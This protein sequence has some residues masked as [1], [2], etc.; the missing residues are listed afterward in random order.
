MVFLSSKTQAPIFSLGPCE[1][2]E[3]EDYILKN[4]WTSS[5]WLQEHDLQQE[6]AELL[7]K[8][9]KI[10]LLLLLSPPP[11]SQL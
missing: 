1:S 3:R 4:S 10:I 2:R 9:K 8:V 11:E 7:H 6:N 5:F